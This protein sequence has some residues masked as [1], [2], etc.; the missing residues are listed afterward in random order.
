[1]FERVKELCK[2]RRISLTDLSRALGWNEN[3]IYHW[4]KTSPSAEKV[5]MV[6]NYF[7]VSIDWLLNGDEAA[8][9]VATP[10]YAT[11]YLIDLSDRSED[12][13][14]EF[15]KEMEMMSQFVANRIRAKKGE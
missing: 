14:D 6:A 4:K 15:E 9:E 11:L 1:M 10:S 2:S 5:Q 3:S 13:K 12:E 7:G 8:K